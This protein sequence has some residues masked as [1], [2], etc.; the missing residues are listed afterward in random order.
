MISTGFWAQAQSPVLPDST[1][2][3]QSP[4][5][6]DLFLAGNF[7]ELRD[8]HFHAGLDFKTQGTINHPVYSFADGYVCRVGINALGYGQVVYV[9]HPQLGLTSVYAHLN[10][11][12]EEIYN[13]L[14]KRQVER[15]E[16]NIQVSFSPD[17]IPVHQGDVIA[18]SGNTGSSGGPHVHFEL[19]DCNDADDEFFNPMPFFRDKIA[20]HKPPRA[21]RI[22]LYPLGGVVSNLTTRQTASIIV[23]QTGQ[24]TINRKFTAWG[25]IGLGIKAFDYIENQCNTY[26]VYRI[27]LYVDDKLIYHFVTDR[28]KYSERRYTNSLTDFRGWV[29][30]R[31]MIQKSFVDPGNNLRMI[32]RTLG[33]GTIYI[34]EE[35]PYQIKYV[36]TD[37]HGNQGT[38]EF[39]IVG[40]KSPLPRDPY[41]DIP[42]G[43]MTDK[44]IMVRVD[45]PLEYDSLG[46]SLRM[47]AGNLYVTTPLPYKHSVL[48]DLQKP[49]YSEVYAVGNASMPVHQYYSMSI[50]LF[51][52]LV[53]SLKHPEQLYIAN[54]AGGYVGGKYR[55]G[56]MH[57]RLQEFGRFVVRRDTTKPSAAIVSMTWGKAQIS[58]SDTGSGVAAYKVFID[59]QF[60]PFDLNRYGRRLGQPRYYSIQRGKMHQVRIWVKDRCGN[61]NTLEFKKFF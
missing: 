50:P 21:S 34:E 40:K 59:D 45:E 61:E 9:R 58:V 43:T 56:A 28:F 19:R 18:F 7:A 48:N 36:L 54:L 41:A 13:V 57:V 14:R 24:T 6:M 37:A 15:E 8:N 33:D 10:A 38:V 5:D 27:Q 44:G 1:M 3:Y 55:D 11:F 20:D 51:P 46:F 2:S 23:T 42:S 4:L 47:P 30:Q 26:G 60:V 35:R 31:T 39:Q 52:W 16:N 49:S 32:D 12:S 22:Y 53:D 25:R 17:E 29:N